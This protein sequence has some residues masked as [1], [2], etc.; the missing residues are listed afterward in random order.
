MTAVPRHSDIISISRSSAS[1]KDQCVDS[2]M[3][4]I[5]AIPLASV[6]IFA[7]P[8]FVPLLDCARQRLRANGNTCRNINEHMES[9]LLNY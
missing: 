4:E 9:G 1:S 2:F 5:E 3:N 6:E 8:P 7:T